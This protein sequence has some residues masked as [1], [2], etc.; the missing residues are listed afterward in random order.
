MQKGLTT[1]Q[2]IEL[3]KQGKNEFAQAKKKSILAIFFEEFLSPLILL[4]TVAA[5]ISFVT[6]EFVDGGIILAVVLAN[7]TIATVQQVSA[8]KSVEKLRQMST[9]TAIVIRDGKEQI[10]PSTE[11]VVGDYVILEAG[12]IVPADLKLVSTSSL[13]INESALT[14]ESITAEKDAQFISDEKTALG[15]QK[16]RAF[17][18][19]LIEYGRGE[20]IVEKIGNDTEIGKISKMLN[21]ISKDETPLQ[22]NLNKI[23]M[24]LGIVGIILCIMMFICQAFIY[25]TEIIETLMI[26]I[27]F[28]VAV[29]PEGLATVVTLVLTMGIKKMSERN[30]IVKQIHAVE[31]LGAVNIICSDKT[32]TLTQNKM[33]VVKW[34]YNGEEKELEDVKNND[35]LFIKL[36][37]GFCLCND[38]TYSEKDGTSTGDPTEVAFVKYAKENQFDFD[39]IKKENERFDEIPFDSDRKMMTTLHR[40]GDKTISF[41]KGAIDSII[42]R[43]DRILDKNGVR[44]ITN[45]DVLVAT[46]TAEKMSSDALRV[47]ALAYREGD[48]KPQEENMIFV[49]LSAMIDPP[50]EGVKETIAECHNAGIEVAMI[51]GDHKVTAF[52]IA[53]ELNMVNDI[54]QCISG[55]E[56]DEMDK[57]E[58]RKN[59]MNYRVF[60]RVSPEHKVQI[61]DA[62]QSHDKICSMTGDGVNDAPSLKTANIGVAMGIGGTEVA[63]DAA[64][65]ILVD[66][67]FITIKNAVM[68]GRNLFNNIKKSI[69]YL[70]RANLGEVVLM[71]SAIFA[72]MASPLSTIQ[73]L[74]VNLL[75]D[76]IPSLALGMDK[77]TNDVMKEQP[78]DVKKGLLNKSDYSSIL[79]QGVICGLTALVAFM[80]PALY[81]H[82]INGFINAIATDAELLSMCRTYA[83]ST[84]VINELLMAYVC[85]STRRLAFF[86]KESWNNKV[87]NISTAFG[88]LLQVA[89]LTFAPLRNLLKLSIC[90][91]N[92]IGMIF[93]IAIIGVA[94]NA[95]LTM[96][97][98]AIVSNK[99]EAK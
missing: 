35:S 33:T 96:C 66:D 41:T 79:V 47:L 1:E 84:L 46:S 7:C 26:S 45:K 2:V 74:W 27:A 88:I 25:H 4:L 49:G 92:D 11:L 97:K 64:D 60:A 15:D 63:K 28:A 81:E 24:V 68:E 37:N 39:Q 6:G 18:S 76:T 82:G 73:I 8:E 43:C 51:T 9:A 21:D 23:S 31:T 91:P 99:Q 36:L 3:Q 59:I 78:R 94:V 56:I 90:T 10:I 34:F 83:F 20:G 75:T 55:Q 58:F 86:S 71:A 65:M 40:S 61:V 30:A 93:L 14:G 85:K 57:E 77:S 62:F 32:G 12:R 5:I 50:K 16:D 48:E 38:A 70:L 69:I 67:N 72:G 80:L 29:I 54:S 44:K 89:V 95:V 42:V 52:A 17:M 13:R 53:R 22:K 98:H 87:L 19:T